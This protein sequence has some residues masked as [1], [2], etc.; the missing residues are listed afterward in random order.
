MGHSTGHGT[1]TAE[2]LPPPRIILLIEVVGPWERFVI[3]E[4]LVVI[5]HTLVRHGT[6]EDRV[7]RSVSELI[8]AYSVT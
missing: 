2:E 4:L 8:L 6:G 5:G 7:K 3:L 1:S